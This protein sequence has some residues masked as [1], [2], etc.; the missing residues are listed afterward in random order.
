MIFTEGN[1]ELSGP[2]SYLLVLVSC[3]DGG[4]YVIIDGSGHECPEVVSNPRT[5]TPS[6]N[7]ANELSL[8]HGASLTCPRRELCRSAALLET[9]LR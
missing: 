8:Y 7:Q 5:H 2:D 4:A 1:R 6:L 9:H 3:F